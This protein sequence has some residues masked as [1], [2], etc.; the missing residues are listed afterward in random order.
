MPVYVNEQNTNQEPQIILPVLKINNESKING[1]KMN[2]EVVEVDP[3]VR[4]Q[5]EEAWS[6]THRRKPKYRGFVDAVWI[7]DYPVYNLL[8]KNGNIPESNDA[9]KGDSGESDVSPEVITQWEVCF[10]TGKY[11][12][13][14]FEGPC[15]TYHKGK[16]NLGM[17]FCKLRGWLQFLGHKCT[18][19]DKFE[20]VWRGRFVE[21][22]D[23]WGT[24]QPASYWEQVA[25]SLENKDAKETGE[26][27]QSPR[28]IDNLVGSLLNIHALT[29][30]EIYDKKGTKTDYYLMRKLK[31]L[32]VKDSQVEEVKRGFWKVVDKSMVFDSGGVGKSTTTADRSKRRDI[33]SI[34]RQQHP[35]AKIIEKTVAPQLTG[36]YA[37]EVIE[38]VLSAYAEDKT[39]EIRLVLTFTA[40]KGQASKIEKPRQKWRNFF[41]NPAAQFLKHLHL[42]SILITEDF[43]YDLDPFYNKVIVEFFP[44]VDGETES[45]YTN[46]ELF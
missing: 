10:K 40:Y 21:M 32:K 22:E 43:S 14:S 19:E 20:G 13:F 41:K 30:I 1:E 35:N 28:N 38:E 6:L 33:L 8:D 25:K 23:E 15:V 12:S 31:D 24:M 45:F 29:H 18:P 3:V 37:E 46:K 26:F 42:Y 16:D 34:Y 44:Q 17:G 36:K 9:R 27:I 2:L 39:R 11:N 7:P 4:K 5:I